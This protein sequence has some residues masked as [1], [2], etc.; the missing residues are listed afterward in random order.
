MA[1]NLGDHKVHMCFSTMLTQDHINLHLR[2]VVVF[3]E[4]QLSEKVD[5]TPTNHLG[6]ENKFNHTISYKMAWNDK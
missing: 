2:L 5:T 6:Y 1:S 4:E 3:M